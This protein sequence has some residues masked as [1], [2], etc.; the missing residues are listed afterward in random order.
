M[1]G[2]T[3]PP[4]GSKPSPRAT[5]AQ[6]AR[7]LPRGRPAGGCV[8]CCVLLSPLSRLHARIQAHGRLSR[9]VGAARA[10]NFIRPSISSGRP[11]LFLGAT[12]VAPPV[13]CT[14]ACPGTTNI[15]LAP[16]PP[17]FC[18]PLD[19]VVKGRLCQRAFH[20]NER[21]RR[22]LLLRKREPSPSP[23][24]P[25]PTRP[26]CRLLLTQQH[27]TI[28]TPDSRSTRGPRN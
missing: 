22:L 7:P 18:L 6:P 27:P 25:P 26:P 19:P 2:A 16:S 8:R 3:P 9:P 5:Q 1:S 21:E 12:A 11:C 20:C 4:N 17:P 23:P 10:L 13:K 28:S 24:S 14:E 15:A